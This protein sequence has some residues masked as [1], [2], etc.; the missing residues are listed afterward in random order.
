MPVFRFRLGRILELKERLR[1][2]K[3]AELLSVER[4][5]E[6]R[7]RRIEALEE[8]I[9]RLETTSLLSGEELKARYNRFELAVVEIERVREE[10]YELEK[11]RKQL[12]KELVDMEKE[13]KMLDKLRDRKKGEFLKDV[14]REEMKFLDELAQRSRGYE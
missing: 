8:E 12:L 13:V 4:E 14:L 1:E 3:R 11:K 7:N 2:A 5:I 6:A 9:R 10:I